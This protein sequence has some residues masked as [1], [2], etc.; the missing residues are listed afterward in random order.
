MCQSR[1]G[2]ADPQQRLRLIGRLLAALLLL[3]GLAGGAAAEEEEAG[4]HASDIELPVGK[5]LGREDDRVWLGIGVFNLFPNNGAGR[6]ADF[7][8]E[9]RLGHKVFSI[10]PLVGLSVNSD[11]GV[12]GYGGIYSNYQVGQF[13]ITPSLRVGGYAKNGSK[14]LGS[15]FQMETSLQ[16]AYEF[17][18]GM[19]LG[20]RFSHISNAGLKDKNPGA[21]TLLLSYSLPM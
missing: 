10:G 8:G 19:R 15:I 9:Y 2:E 20:V 21:E 7:V 12:Y 17:Q 18:N 6:S 13:L 5:L 11:G 16:G 3:F 4:R 14:D 1:A